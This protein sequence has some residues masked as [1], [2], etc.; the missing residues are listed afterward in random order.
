M[1]FLSG[2]SKGCFKY[3]LVAWEKVSSPIEV[4]GV[5]IRNVVSFNKALLGK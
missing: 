2:S 4:G 3:P 1:N 5:G